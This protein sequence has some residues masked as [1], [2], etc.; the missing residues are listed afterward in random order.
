MEWNRFLQKELAKKG[1]TNLDSE[2]FNYAKGGKSKE[3]NERLSY[4]NNVWVYSACQAITRNIVQL[5][6]ALDYTNTTNKELITNHQILDLFNAPN[7]M[8]DRASFWETIILNLL[9][10]TPNTDGGQCFL[11]FETG[12]PS[13][14]FSVSR[15]DIPK[16]IYPFSSEFVKAVK[17]SK[18]ILVGWQLIIGQ[19]KINYTLDEVIRINFT[20]PD[21][22][23]GGMCPLVSAYPSLREDIKAQLVN[24]TFF[25]NNASL[26]GTLK[27]NAELSLEQI[28]EIRE[29]WESMYGGGANA[30]KDAILHSG[31]EYQQFQ[32]THLEMQFLEQRKWTRDQVLAVYGVPKAEVSSYEDLNYATAIT[33]NKSFW[34]KTLL[35]LDKRIL[36][37]LNKWV[38]KVDRGVYTLVSDYTRVEALQD[39]YANKLEQAKLMM[40]LNI[41]LSIINTR[42]K[43]DLDLSKV[44]WADTALISYGL[45]PA[46]MVMSGDTYPDYATPEEDTTPT[47]TEGE[48]EEKSTLHRAGSMHYLA[49]YHKEVLI[50]SEKKFKKDLVKFFVGQRNKVLDSIDT[51]VNTNKSITGSVL[52]AKKEPINFILDKAEQ[53]KTIKSLM[54]PSYKAS[55]QLE[56]SRLSKE[57]EVINWDENGS[58]LKK[59]LKDRMN[60][61][62][63]VNT[64]T[65][66]A[67]STRVNAVMKQAIEEDL[68]ITDISQLLK[69][70]IRTLFNNPAR[71]NTIARTESAA[72]HSIARQDILKSAEV[73]EVEWVTAGDERVR[74]VGTDTFSHIELDGQVIKIGEVFNNGEDIS[75]PHDPNA[76]AGNVINCRCI[77]VPIIKGE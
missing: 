45:V 42:L 46:E 33:A 14:K 66:K 47:N 32:R 16:E 18:N 37:S 75:Y 35:P 57:V 39:N 68:S 7:P 41:P 29:Q 44:V 53:D 72:I 20:D 63:N 62:A 26:G 40:G 71:A 31:L 51:W 69:S 52:K 70:N 36:E 59:A 64:T 25:D 12:S 48:G 74:G 22:P 27:T 67:I 28:K 54:L 2:F 6:K 38:G 43:L 15:G 58:A 8:M 17:D 4:K 73:E 50:P 49:Q 56:A 3:V 9:L 5:P 13:K 21:D 76:S 10:P 61:L 77:V 55:I 23:S 65:N 24:E 11:V 1:Y 30:G 19:Q 34:D 60:V